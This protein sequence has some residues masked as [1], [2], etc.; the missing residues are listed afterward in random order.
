MDTSQ[1]SASVLL[2]SPSSDVVALP[3]FSCIGELVSVSAVSVARSAVLPPGV[4]RTLPG[5][6]EDI[7]VG[8]LP[9]LDW[10]G[11]Q[12]SGLSCI[13]MLTCFP[14]PGASHRTYYGSPT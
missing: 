2:V 13:S 8:S 4:D 11:G 9:S 1:W 7:V 3:S 5:H 10:R 14:L 12:S 6:L